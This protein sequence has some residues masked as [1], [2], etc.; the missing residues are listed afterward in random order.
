[1]DALELVD[2]GDTYIVQGKLNEAIPFYERAL[3]ADPLC[4]EAWVGKGSALKSLNLLKDALACYEKALAIDP[5]SI[6]SQSM[7]DYLL[8]ELMNKG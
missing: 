8:E 4:Y 3:T 5:G 6:I 1:M 2:Q 7:I